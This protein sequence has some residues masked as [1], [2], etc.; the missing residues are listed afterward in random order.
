MQAGVQWSRL[1]NIGELYPP[2][3]SRIDNVFPNFGIGHWQWGNNLGAIKRFG[4]LSTKK[5]V[6]FVNGYFMASSTQ[7]QKIIDD[8]KEKFVGP[9]E[10]AGENCGY[11]PYG[12]GR[13]MVYYLEAFER[14]YI[15]CDPLKKK[16][17]TNKTFMCPGV[18]MN[19]SAIQYFWLGQPANTY[20]K[21]RAMYGAYAY[22]WRVQ[23]HNRDRNGNGISEGFYS[24]GYAQRYSLLYDAP[25]IYGLYVKIK[26]DGRYKT[27]VKEVKAARRTLADNYNLRADTI[28]SIWF[29]ERGTEGTSRRYG[30]ITYSCDGSDSL[31]SDGLCEYVSK[32]QALATSPNFYDHKC[33]E[34]LLAIGACFDP[35]MSMRYAQGFFPGG[36]LLD[37]FGYGG[38]TSA[39]DI[40]DKN[41]RIVP[42]AT[43]DSRGSLNTKDELSTTDINLK[44]RSPLNTPHAR[45]TRGLKSVGGE[46]QSPEFVAGVTPCQDGGA[47]HC[48]YITPT[49]HLGGSSYLLGDGNIFSWLKNYAAEVYYSEYNIRGEIT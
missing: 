35:C 14:F 9:S 40:N 2:S 38:G 22:Q 17:V 25:A 44:F 48:N 11:T 49:I 13:N 18:R 30:D 46:V 33:P 12:L 1:T 19:N 39:N 37:L 41:V 43:V 32:A 45:I 42:I 10:L 34:A 8:V 6:R 29:G 16:N 5:D 28:R 4:K 24:M 7:G 23:R 26:T 15:I 36:K 20:V 27:A 21:R 47:D 3:N 31:F